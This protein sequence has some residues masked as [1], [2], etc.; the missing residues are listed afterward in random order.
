MNSLNIHVLE[1]HVNLSSGIV[2]LPL[3]GSRLKRRCTIRCDISPQFSIQD[4]QRQIAFLDGLSVFCV[5]FL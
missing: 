1:M 3:Y 5:I 2:G 4:V